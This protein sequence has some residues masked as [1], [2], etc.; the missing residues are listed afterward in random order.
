MCVRAHVCIHT[1]TYMYFF[2]ASFHSS[3]MITPHTHTLDHVVH[4]IVSN[5]M[6]SI[7]Y[8]INV[9]PGLEFW[10]WTSTRCPLLLACS[11]SGPV[12]PVG[13]VNER[14]EVLLPFASCCNDA[15]V[16]LLPALVLL[17]FLLGGGDGD[18]LVAMLLLGSL[19]LVGGTGVSFHCCCC[20]RLIRRDSTLSPP[21]S[22]AR[23][24]SWSCNASW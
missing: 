16:P 15:A 8:H 18:A 5:R 22:T 13:D 20:P 17:L 12:A 2:R 19:L 6:N 9:S 11:G 3:T 14:V 7:H 23:R 1:Y 10:N 4:F 21:F 24:S